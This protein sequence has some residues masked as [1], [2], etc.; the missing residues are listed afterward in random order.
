MHNILL[1]LAHNTM[2][3]AT[4]A[5]SYIHTSEK[6]KKLCVG[7]VFSHNQFFIFPAVTNVDISVYQYSKTFHIFFNAPVN[8]N[9]CPP[10][11]PRPGTSRALAGD[12]QHFV[13]LLVNHVISK[14]NESYSPLCPGSGGAE[15]YI[16]WCITPFINMS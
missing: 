12:S 14:A 3:V 10:P 7:R 8:I 11:L 1:W 5:Y 2:R 13:S 6:N 16:D 15:I 9:L 4:R